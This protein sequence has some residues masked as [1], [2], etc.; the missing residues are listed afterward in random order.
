MKILKLTQILN[1]QTGNWVNAKVV[2]YNNKIYIIKNDDFEKKVLIESDAKL[3][4]LLYSKRKKANSKCK[5]NHLVIEPSMV[6]DLKCPICFTAGQLEDISLF[7]I[8]KEVSKHENK[9]VSISG[10]EPTLRKDLREIIK[11][12]V[13]KNIP[14]LATHGV[15]LADYNYVK[16]LKEVGL[17]HV[18]FSL[19]GLTETSFIKIN[20]QALLKQKLKAIENLVKADMKFLL[21]MLLV[22][23]INEKQIRPIVN[24]AVQYPNNI[25]EVRI[26]S[27]GRMGKYFNSSPFFIS[28]I[29]NLVCKNLKINKLD[30]YKELNF[31]KKL[32]GKFSYINILQKICGFSF[33]L[34][35]GKN[36]SYQPLGK[37]LNLQNNSWPRS[38]YNIYRNRE[39]YSIIKKWQM[40]FKENNSSIWSHNK[41]FLKISLRHWPDINTLDFQEHFQQCRS[42]YIVGEKRVLPVCYANIIKDL[43]GSRGS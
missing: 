28:E 37:H 8:K 10:G 11:I 20:G 38:L 35:L 30:I 13:K 25:K 1:P 41:N 23:G 31:K 14:L 26:R 5:I 9:I 6:C 16:Q 4:K 34:K 24:L 15:R 2:E 19:N 29:L 42:R 32:L 7:E 40:P 18:T 3:Y 27:M 21:S 17:K 33:Y 43:D 36:N 22:R 39:I 12:I